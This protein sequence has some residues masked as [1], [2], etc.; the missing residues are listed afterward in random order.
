MKFRSYSIKLRKIFKLRRLKENQRIIIILIF[1]FVINIS[2][3]LTRYF[4]NITKKKL[5]KNFVNIKEA[6]FF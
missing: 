5:K 2:K 4:N 3:K 1:F 6:Y